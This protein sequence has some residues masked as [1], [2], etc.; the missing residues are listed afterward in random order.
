MA[1]SQHLSCAIGVCVLAVATCARADAA[2]GAEETRTPRASELEEIVVTAR[3]REESILNVPLSVTAIG[4]AELER[5]GVKNLEEFARSVPGLVVIQEGEQAA[6]TF[7][8]RGVGTNTPQST[9][10]VYVDDTPV[11]FGPDSPDLKLYDIARVEV[12]RGP[13]GTLFGSSS[14]GGA[15]R[16][17]MARPD[18]ER[19]GGRASVEGGTTSHGNETYEAQVS[20]TGP[21]VADRL[22]F[23]GSLF[24]RRDGGYVDLVDEDTGAVIDADSNTEDSYG[25]RLALASSFGRLDATLSLM[26]QKME[27]DSPPH[28]FTARQITNPILL[29]RLQRTERAEN[30]RHE[31]LSLPNLT[32]KA[33]VGIGELT[34]S[35]S[36]VKREVEQAND[37]SYFIQS[38]FGLP[39]SVGR[40]L[41]ASNRAKDEFTGVVQELRLASRGES[42]LD[43][44]V[45]AYYRDTQWHLSGAVSSPTLVQIIPPFASLLLPGNVLFLLDSTTTSTQWAGFGEL[46]YTFADRWTLTGGLRYT[47]LDFGIDRVGNGLFNGGPSSLKARS[48]E[49]IV[50][51]KYSI[52]YR[53]SEHANLYASAAKGF[54]EG[55]ANLPVPAALPACA[56]ALAALGRTDV[57]AGYGSDTLWSYELGAKVRNQAVEIR[58]AIYYIDWNK[59]QEVLVLQGA[60]GFAYFDNVG[61]A[62]SRGAEAE[63]SL[64]PA[65]AWT[66]DLSLGYT[67]TQLTKPLIS[68]ASSSG[69]VIAAP[70]GTQLPNVPDWTG[71]LAVQYDFAMSDNWHGYVRADHQYI[72]SS[73]RYLVN[74]DPSVLNRDSY[75]L[76]AL[77]VGLNRGPYEFSLYADNLFD[78]DVVLYDSSQTGAR[79]SGH[80]QSTVRPRVIGATFAWRF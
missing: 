79:N 26:Y 12:L 37:Y 35:T 74:A 34:S 70:A 28:Y 4:A 48:T 63:L 59:I 78:E 39:D 65:E 27:Q 42:A 1:G 15:V 75:Q 61:T 6:R 52:S 22:A 67:D 58:S 54:R 73:T 77:H 3:K 66:V 9:V 45:G 40:P 49:N 80:V 38:A 76:T 57:P 44:M 11:T 8:I 17:V 16:Y 30:W 29:G 69:P 71:S 47:D 43:W 64:H 51:P 32:L 19:F 41:S 13:Q 36:Y 5:M 31:Q 25:G 55:G 20:A 62:R 21:I 2:W 50:T 68:G 7:L 33:D 56:Q 46:S 72:G 60:C 24:T 23:H 53:L 18:F 10:A 14:M